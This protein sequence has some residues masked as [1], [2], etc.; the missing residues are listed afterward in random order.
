MFSNDTMGM[1]GPTAP[2]GDFVRTQMT[3]PQRKGL[4]AQPGFL[5][6]KSLPDGSS[7][8]RRGSFVLDKLACQPPP[9]PPAGVAIV[10]PAPSTSAT[11]RERFDDHVK[12]PNCNGCHQFIDPPGFTFEHYDG[13]GRWR[14]TENG[15]VIDATGGIVNA[16]EDG[17]RAPVDG[18]DQLQALVAGSRQVHDCM[19]KQFFNFALGRDAVEA[20]RCTLQRIGDRFM[21]SGGDFKQLML[22]IVQSDA[23]RQNANPEMTP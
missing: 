6:F 17:L 15:H 23:F 18:A 4:L 14:D 13:L 22:A 21:G 7:P 12:D 3:G 16:K 2:N 5:A 19:A 8:V 1:Y 9:P 20:D 11:T 10:P